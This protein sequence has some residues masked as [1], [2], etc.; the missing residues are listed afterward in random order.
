[1]KLSPEIEKIVEISDPLYTFCEVLD[2]IDPKSYLVVGENKA[3]RKRFDSETLL[4]VIL[5]AFMEHGYAAI[6][7]I[8]KLGKTDIRF[9]IC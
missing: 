4:K 8:K 3:G 7:E 5:F 9:S 6:R 2:Q 1:M